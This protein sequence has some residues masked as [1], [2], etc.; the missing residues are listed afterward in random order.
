M[1]LM[2]V[3]INAWKGSYSVQT[4]LSSF[5]SLFFDPSPALLLDVRGCFISIE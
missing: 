1:S 2:D 5:G 3:P 4:F